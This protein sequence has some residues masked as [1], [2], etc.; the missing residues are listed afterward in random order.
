VTKEAVRNREE[1]IRKAGVYLTKFFT[2]A[3]FFG[4]CTESVKN[5]T[6]NATYIFELV[7]TDV[8]AVFTSST[9]RLQVSVIDWHL[10]RSNATT[11][12]THKELYA[13]NGNTRV[14]SP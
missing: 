2:R 5:R 7:L 1:R 12:N 4:C 14:L 9:I 11:F 13:N 3:K 8:K 6:I 10:M